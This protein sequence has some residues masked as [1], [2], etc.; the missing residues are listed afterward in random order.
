MPE[1]IRNAP[2]LF[3][4][5]YDIYE[6]FFELL[7]CLT[8]EGRVPWTAIMQYAKAH[9]LASTPSELQSFTGLIRAMEK[10][11]S[12]HRQAERDKADKAANRGKKRGLK[13]G[14][15]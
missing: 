11:Y 10:A 13:N 5:L 2:T 7:S 4:W 14:G 15:A 6:A 8:T 9:S 12:D 3:P 1:R